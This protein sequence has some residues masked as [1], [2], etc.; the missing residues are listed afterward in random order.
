MK[1]HYKV[2]CFGL[3]SIMI[4]TAV[5]GGGSL[6]RGNVNSV[7]AQT[8]SN[9]IIGYVG[10]QGN[11]Y[12]SPLFNGRKT[13]IYKI[14]N[15]DQVFSFPGCN[16]IDTV[17][18]DAMDPGG[19]MLVTC[20]LGQT[21]SQVA[22]LTGIGTYKNIW[23]T[24]NC[25][26]ITIKVIPPPP[27]PLTNIC[28][29]TPSQPISGQEVTIRNA[30][31]SPKGGG[32]LNVQF[33]SGRGNSLLAFGRFLTTGQNFSML[34][35]VLVGPGQYTVVISQ[36]G[37]SVCSNTLSLTV[38]PPAVVDA[39]PTGLS[40]N[41][42]LNARN[43]S[44]SWSIPSGATISSIEVERAD[45]LSD[46][47][48]IGAYNKVATLGADATSYIDDIKN[49][50]S[51]FPLHYRIRAKLS[52]GSYSSFS[53]VAVVASCVNI[54]GSGQKKILFMR[55]AST[56]LSTAEYLDFIRILV[57][58]GFKTI[59][60]FKKY[61]NNF[62][63]YAD[64]AVTADEI[65]SAG[66]IGKMDASVKNYNTCKGVS[67]NFDVYITLSSKPLLDLL[68]GALASNI[69]RGF[70][71]MNPHSNIFAGNV[72]AGKEPLVLMH[73]VG[74]A[75][76][77]LKDEYIKHVTGDFETYVT[78]SWS[79]NGEN[80]SS[81]PAWDYKN[82]ADNRL[83]GSV[84]TRGC[85][86]FSSGGIPRDSELYF[87]PS[88]NSIMK[89]SAEMV[90]GQ[91]VL[92]MGDN[93]NVVSC[94]YIMAAINGQALTQAVASKYFPE[95]KAM[96]PAP[97]VNGVVPDTSSGTANTFKVSGS[98][99]NT[100]ENLIKLIPVSSGAMISS[101]DR[102]ANIFSAFDVIWEQ[103]KN[104]VPFVHGQTTVSTGYYLINNIPA[105]GAS[106]S[107]TVPSNV[108][109]G[110]YKVSV[111]GV[112]SPWN[113]T[114][115]TIVVSGNGAGDP[116]TAIVEDLPPTVQKP[117]P[118]GKILKL[119]GRSASVAS[120]RAG[121]VTLSW[122][123]PSGLSIPG[124]NLYNSDSRGIASGAPIL[125]N[126]N[127]TTYTVTGLILGKK[128]CWSV[129]PSA[130]YYAKQYNS[131]CWQVFTSSR[132]SATT[133]PVVV[134]PTPVVP[135]GLNVTG[136]ICNASNLPKNNTYYGVSI[137]V[138]GSAAGGVS[139]YS[140]E[141]LRSPILRSLEGTT[142]SVPARN[143]LPISAS[144]ATVTSNNS[145]GWYVNVN[146]SDGKYAK[147]NCKA[148]N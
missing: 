85:L 69:D 11:R 4:L 130:I 113:D 3:V 39:T 58:G 43:V 61:I 78:K 33:D 147:V 48:S 60:P 56:Y 148:L 116:S 53:N 112:D 109:D 35:P 120:A 91:L 40:A 105:N 108:P 29:L 82:A 144:W 34:F 54:E 90:N 30:E 64:F 19:S 95:C 124:Y 106:L 46:D 18:I 101:D 44:L 22:T 77:G 75:F 57:D 23:P 129:Q 72:F 134:T 115:Y 146:S 76:A 52:D 6:I 13:N 135:A 62:S 96:S 27:P 142:A 86:M 114:S 110:K 84:V 107:F 94:G 12:C 65:G 136:V 145:S 17:Q 67:S 24:G 103:L 80:C 131:Y 119:I 32:M 49:L 68:G 37:D 31:Q 26:T 81:Q 125:S 128:Y 127:L 15:T 133:T 137:N 117:L 59:N 2:C 123:V 1:K 89:T 87:R 99:F 70:V 50:T 14:I 140:Y 139:P 25:S 138:Q 118:T 8:G 10:I 55:G 121:E 42:S 83:Y 98:E 47:V 122:T 20:N 63:F 45:T 143:Y 66:D 88:E 132:G 5:I 93:F 111:S 100:S 102:V 36:S 28:T 92:T 41:F 38:L 16:T 104:L 141:L 7:N 71:Y 51:S 9:T 79:G 97:K 126:T 73:E 74:H 21:G